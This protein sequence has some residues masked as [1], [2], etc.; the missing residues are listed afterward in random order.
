MQIFRQKSTDKNHISDTKALVEQKNITQ[1]HQNGKQVKIEKLL[2]AL[3]SEL[4]KHSSQIEQLKIWKQITERLEN[5]PQHSKILRATIELST[6]SL[7]YAS[8]IFCELMDMEPRNKLETPLNIKLH[9][10]FNDGDRQELEK[11]YRIQVLSWV[12]KQVDQIDT[13]YLEYQ[14]FSVILTVNSPENSEPKYI[15]FWF[16]PQ[17]V[18]VTRIDQRIDEFRD[19]NLQGMSKSEQLTWLLQWENLEMLAQKL[20]LEN[21]QIE[22]FLLLEGLDVTVKEKTRRLIQLLVEPESLIEEAKF[23]QIDKLIRALFRADDMILLRNEGEKQFKLFVASDFLTR[24]NYPKQYSIESLQSSLIINTIKENRIVNIPEF[25]A[26]CTNEFEQHL[27]QKGVRSLI[28]ISL[29]I[30]SGSPKEEL[31][32]TDILGIV[33][34]ISNNS[35]NFNLCDYKNAQEL[36]PAFTTAVR[37]TIQQR[38]TNIRNIHPAVEWRFL[39][40]AERRRWGLPPETIVFEDVY[41]LYGICDIRGSS[42]E[43]NRAIQSDIMA[44]FCLGLAI[45]E[46]VCEKQDSA[47]CQQLRQ[48][49]LEYIKSLEEK[50]SVDTEMTA[51]E[52]LRCRL[53]VYFDYFV[54]LGDT[55]E[56][57]IQAYCAACNNADYGIYQA[58]EVYD[59]MLNK[60]NYH[61]Q[62]TWEK[63]QKQMQQIIPHHC[64]FEATDGIDHMM[65]LGKSINSEFNQFHLHSLRYDQLRAICDCARTALLLQVESEEHILGVAHLILVQHSTIDIYHNESTERLFDVKGSRDIRYEIVK[66]RIDKAVDKDT[67]ERITQPGMLTV[68]YSTDEEWEEYEQYLRY[69]VRE[70]WVEDKFETGLIEALQGVSG[71]RFVRAKV[72]LPE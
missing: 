49:M 8:D 26:D 64:D 24:V 35:S 55:V 45:V 32:L 37:Q 29:V 48:D 70:G 30:Q 9:E 40:E 28:L 72:L 4:P 42:V 34:L 33:G 2:P 16:C 25:E 27:F 41:P 6:M 59:Q 12:L 21:Y 19:F 10:L 1:N 53:E 58:R 38:F 46:A 52:Y 66:K 47:L 60:I 62:N 11:L 57:A 71:L 31:E 68:V 51:L 17:K 63:W 50:V 54:K 18:K 69:L 44:Q 5:P 65:Y 13:E 43:R 36:V 3:V 7:Q 39:Q 56:D 20:R 14:D 15:E 23:E 22:G 61:L 67:Q